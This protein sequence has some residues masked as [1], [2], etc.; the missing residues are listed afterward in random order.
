MPSAT[1]R[2][3]SGPLFGGQL[4]HEVF[5]ETLPIAL[6]RLKQHFGGDAV[7][8]GQVFIEQDLVAAEHEDRLRDVLG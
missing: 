7:E 5:R 8:C 6:D 1:R 2:P 4:D 3:Q